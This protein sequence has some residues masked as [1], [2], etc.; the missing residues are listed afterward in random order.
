MAL[1]NIV[2]ATVLDLNGGTLPYLPS[3]KYWYKDVTVTKTEI[4]SRIGDSDPSYDLNV[5]IIFE[6]TK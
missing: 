6:Y 2:K 3:D 4:I 5:W 1:R